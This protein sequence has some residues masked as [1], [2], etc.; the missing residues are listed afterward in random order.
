MTQ[1]S[2]WLKQIPR[3]VWWSFFPGFGGLAI[4][5]AGYKSQTR[6]WIAWG[7]GLTVLALASSSLTQ[8]AGWVWIA[9]IVVAFALKKRYLIKTAPRGLLVPQDT[10]TAALIANV[11]GKI[12][13]NACS[14]DD[15]VKLL[16]LPIVYANEIESLQNEGYIFTHLEELSEIAG[17][18]ESHL[19]RIAP[20]IVFSY[21][22]RKEPAFSWKRLNILSQTELIAS[23]IEP[24]VAQKILL[25]RQTRGNYRSIVDVKRRTGLPLHAYR[26]IV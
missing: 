4:A 17:I 3:W 11:K 15:L 12:D 20:L 23:G 25:E 14:K 1:N 16:G 21:D 6:N 5:Y 8:V 2:L 24:E 7:V 18:P 26:S 9:Q 22:I 10:Q 13:I 19:Q